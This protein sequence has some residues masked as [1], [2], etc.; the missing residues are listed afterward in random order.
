MR[1]WGL[2]LRLL[3][4]RLKFSNMVALGSGIRASEPVAD[5]FPLAIP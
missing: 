3:G 2:R 4:L 5:G 1:L